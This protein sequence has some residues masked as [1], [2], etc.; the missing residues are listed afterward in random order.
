MNLSMTADDV[1]TVFS[2]VAW[3]AA[4]TTEDL[5]FGKKKYHFIFILFSFFHK[6]QKG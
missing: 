3:H 2:F 4:E 5:K 6:L 1:F